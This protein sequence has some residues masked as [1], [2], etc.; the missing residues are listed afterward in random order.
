MNKS[1]K[2]KGGTLCAGRVVHFV[3]NNHWMSK[4]IISTSETP[5]FGNNQGSR[6]SGH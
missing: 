6:F 3:R 1:A 2:N 4:H 5:I